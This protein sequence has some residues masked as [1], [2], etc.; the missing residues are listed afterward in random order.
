MAKYDVCV[1]GGAGH[2][3]LPLG[4]VLADAGKK[5]VCQDVNSDAV[6]TVNSGRMPFLE[7]GAEPV[8]KRVLG[9]TFSITSER[10]VIADSR[11]VIVVIGTPVDA[12]LNPQLEMFRYFLES[13]VEFIR[14]GQHIV[15]RSTI[16]PGTSEKVLEFLQSHGLKVK[17]SFCPERIAQG[18]AFEELHTLPQIISSFDEEGLDEVRELF[19]CLGAKLIVLEPMEA[20]LAKLFANSYRYILFSIANQFYQIAVQN[21]QD[22]YRIHDAV[23]LDYPRMN[24]FPGAGFAAGP[25]LFKDTMQL[26]ALSDNNFFLGH[27]A[28]LVNEGLPNFILSQLRSKYDMRGKTI[29]ILGMGFKANIDD[30]RESLS[31]KLMKILQMQGDVLC[32]DVYIEDKR[33]VDVDELIEKSDF[34]IL[35]VPHREYAELTFRK[36]QVVVDMW[37]YYGKGGLF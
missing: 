6:A 17:V 37:N 12:H 10:D 3:G 26:A 30:P 33:F 8:L 28:M 11:Y 21:G 1:I 16:Y 36:D 24:A 7:D 19:R 4:L 25:C 13:I 31:Y 5:V 14:D 20:E 32:S 22:Y 29:G 27:A 34:I 23:T 15:L 18:K 2:V 9:K 35:G